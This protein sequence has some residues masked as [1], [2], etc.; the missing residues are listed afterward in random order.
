MNDLDDLYG[1]GPET[2]SHEAVPAAA[3]SPVNQSS[4]ESDA[5]DSESDIEVIITTKAGQRAEPPSN[6]GLPYAAVKI[7]RPGSS[8]PTASVPVKAPPVAK[9]PEVDVDAIA[10]MD[11]KSILEVDLESLEPKPWRQP[12]ADITEYFNYGF[13][14]FTWTAYCQKQS[15]IRDEYEPGKVMAG[16]MGAMD[17][18]MMAPMNPGMMMP[19]MDP[20]M[21]QQFYGPGPMDFMQDPTAAF[22]APSAPQ[23]LPGRQVQNGMSNSKEHNGFS[24][25]TGDHKDMN[26]PKGP[27]Q[28][29]GNYRSRGNVP[30]R[31]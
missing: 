9:V 4:G 29:R 20:H 7:Q 3:K 25:H 6:K 16:M 2:T 26:I 18:S 8:L 21:M 11:G 27:S 15:N 23:M 31:W 17:G 12:G 14:E 10:E 28:A 1:D 24:T 22:G 30:G 13:D 19:T 5:S